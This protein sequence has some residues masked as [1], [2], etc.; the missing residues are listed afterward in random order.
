M[1]G[2]GLAATSTPINADVWQELLELEAATQPGL[3]REMIETFLNDTG[4]LLQQLPSLATQ[5]GGKPMRLAAH[6]LKSSSASMGALVLSQLL[7]EV[8]K[9]EG[10]SQETITKLLARTAEEWERVRTFLE[11][12]NR[13]RQAA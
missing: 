9:S 7:V 1:K 8:E 6:K 5:N 2:I 3:L 4:S 11:H 12:Q 10:L 13:T